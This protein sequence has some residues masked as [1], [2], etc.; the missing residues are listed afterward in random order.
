MAWMAEQGREGEKRAGRERQVPEK[1]PKDSVHVV[2]GC[3][4]DCGLGG[5][6]RMRLMLLALKKDFCKRR[7]LLCCVSLNG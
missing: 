7:L 3:T 1:S 4:A 6:C 5:K 2:F